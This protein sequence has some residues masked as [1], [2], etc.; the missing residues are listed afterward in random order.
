VTLR[1]SHCIL[2]T[3]CLAVSLCANPV[4]AESPAPTVHWGGL[5]YPDQS[6]TLSGGF[7]MNRFTEFDSQYGAPPFGSTVNES[8]GLNFV[9]LSWTRALTC[10]FCLKGLTMNLT[11]GA[12]PTSE[13][14]SKGIQ[15]MLHRTF[16]GPPVMTRRVR[17]GADGMVDASLTKWFSLQST[18]SGQTYGDT[19]LGGGVSG[20]TLYQELFMRAGFRRLAIPID[21][22][23]PVRFSLM[24]RASRLFTGSLLHNVPAGSL[25]AQPAVSFGPYEGHGPSVPPWEIEF[26]MTWDTGLFVNQAGQSLRTHFWSLS[27]RYHGLKIETWNDSLWNL[28]DRGPTYGMALT[29]NLFWDMAAY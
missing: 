12:G 29:Y 25:Q 7:T 14:P 1:R 21:V 11:A 10:S 8:F 13:Q 27:Y 15:D 5:A 6:P 26:A 3:L 20:G 2:A 24:G 18:E 4:A 22:D 23:L 16:D 28:H 9:S 17:T 19:F